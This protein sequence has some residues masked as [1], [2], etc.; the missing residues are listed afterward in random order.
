MAAATK[1]KG[2]DKKKMSDLIDDDVEVKTGGKHGD[3]SADED[4]GGD[5]DAD[6][7]GNLKGF[8]APDSPAKGGPPPASTGKPLARKEKEARPLSPIQEEEGAPGDEYMMKEEGWAKCLQCGTD[9][10]RRGRAPPDRAAQL[11]AECWGT[12][13]DKGLPEEQLAIV[14]SRDHAVRS[15]ARAAVFEAQRASAL[16][17]ATPEERAQREAKERSLREVWAAAKGKASELVEELLKNVG[18]DVAET[19]LEITMRQPA[20]ARV[21]ATFVSMPQ[22]LRAPYVAELT[23]RLGFDA[24]AD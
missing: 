4:D 18:N 13:R 2:A 17:G 16:A 7:N 1:T 9:P 20:V 8:V 19:A 14:F 3:V 22:E 21:V 6:E 24:P 15:A 5:S 10:T 12:L 11:C 23:R